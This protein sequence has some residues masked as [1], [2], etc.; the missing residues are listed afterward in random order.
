MGRR[1]REPARE[2][3]LGADARRRTVGLLRIRVASARLA[4][5][6]LAL[7]GTFDRAFAQRPQFPLGEE[8]WQYSTFEQDTEIRVSVVTR[9]LSHPW[10]LAF[11]P[12]SA[13]PSSPMGDALITE[14]EGRIRLFRN[15]LLA[16]EPVA[17]L[18][19]FE[20]DQLFDIRPHPDFAANGFIYFTY[21]KQ[22]PHPDG[23]DQY[24]ATTALAR[25]RFD[26]ERLVDTEEIFAADA[27][28]TNF[29][30]DAARVAFTRDGSLY[31][32]SSHR[33]DPD[34]PQRLDTHVGKVLRLNDDGTVPGDNPFAGRAGAL[35]EIYTYGHRTI[36]ALVVHP[37]TGALWEAENGPNGGDEVNILHA[38]KNYGWPVVTYGRDY[39]G[40]RASP[41]PWREGME[42]PELFWVPSITLSSIAFYTGD[43]FP[44]WK[45]NLFVGAM[46]AGRLPGTGHLERIVFNEHGEI[47]REQMLNDLR[48]RIRWVDQGPDD[49]LYLLTDEDDGVLL[50][51]EPAG[52]PQAVQSSRSASGGDATGDG[53][54]APL[55][56][57][58]DCAD[59]HRPDR[60]TVG[61]AYLDIARRYQA[62]ETAVDL[63]AAR[64]IEGSVGIWGEVPMT[65]H[66][67][68]SKAEA[69]TMVARI[70][71]LPAAGRDADADA[72]NG[73]GARR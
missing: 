46:T 60:R 28:H 19:G 38:G 41:T 1:R 30:G 4:L 71:A 18:S 24:W 12:S 29:G 56:G 48:Q 64:I 11:L 61:P 62:S 7:A 53:S 49:L 33:R 25:G 69:R 70:L 37:D 14:K 20:I 21:M 52:L 57:S 58:Y 67:G 44:A 50:R 43:A 45:G 35:P 8:P 22:A 9:G 73:T 36:M 63:L 17:D 65:A 40:S 31:L 47:R 55:F 23:G 51:I 59:C 34:L 3:S 27:W 26:G 54:A 42:Q 15:G 68:I 32:T 5:V 6:C 39:D 72:G 16:P 66:S 2:R 10:S 13:T